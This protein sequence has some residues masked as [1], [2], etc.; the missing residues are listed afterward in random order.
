M[1]P[2]N[3]IKSNAIGPGNKL[4]TLP[5]QTPRG[6]TVMDVSIWRLIMLKTA[7]QSKVSFALLSDDLCCDKMGCLH[8]KKAAV[9]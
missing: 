8:V 4:Y 7:H 5:I 6:N 3:Q 2:N 1:S 9:V